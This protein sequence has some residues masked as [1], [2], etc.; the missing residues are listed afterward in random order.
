MPAPSFG[1]A[2]QL[3][4]IFTVVKLPVYDV[5]DIT[6]HQGKRGDLLPG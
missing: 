6:G 2:Y 3:S 1:F 4:L 5:S